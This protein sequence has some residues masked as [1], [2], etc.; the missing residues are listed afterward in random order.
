MKKNQMTYA[1]ALKVVLNGEPMTD[2]VREK[3][4]ALLASVSKSNKNKDGTPKVNIEKLEL[5]NK[6]YDQMEENRVYGM[7]DLLKELPLVAEYDGAHETPMSNQRM[8]SLMGVLVGDG[9]VSKTIEKR[10]VFY[11]KVI[12]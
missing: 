9:R 5:A 7:P 8:A 4:E 10:K 11:T 12:A 2:E 3:L 6:A 1:N